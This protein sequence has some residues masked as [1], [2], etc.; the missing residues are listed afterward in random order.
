MKLHFVEAHAK[1]KIKLPKK[2]L[3]TLPHSVCLATDVQFINNLPELETQLT[4]HGKQV[5][6]L[7]GAHAK[8]LSQILGCSHIKLN[9]PKLTEAFLYVGD[10]LF[11]PKALLLGSTKD[12]YIYNPFSKEFRRLPHSEVD[13]IMR[14]EKAAILKFLHSDKIG[15]LLTIKPGQIGVQAHL[16]QIYSLEKKY[17]DKKFYYL[18]FDTLEFNQLE[19]FP[20][21][22]C[23]VNTAC[24]RLIDDYDKFPK[25]MVNIDQIL[26][27]DV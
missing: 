24:T 6:K 22:E 12:V 1:I 26:K 16:K 11:H 20:F 5:F 17:P 23:F 27:L 2:V 25:P 3:D 7:K 18:V 10:G 13:K 14:H 15:M 8:H 21:I 19:N 9:Y 4:D